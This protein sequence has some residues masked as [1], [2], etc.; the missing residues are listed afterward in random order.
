MDVAV[1]RVLKPHGIRG[2]LVVEVRTDEPR[3]RFAVGA[4]LGVSQRLPAPPGDRR[5]VTVSSAREHSGRLIVCFEGVADRA[6]AEALRGAVLTVDQAQLPPTDDPE[7]FYDHELVGLTVEL[8]DGGTIG[9][10]ADV[11]HG[12]GGDMLVV[13]REGAPDALVPFVHQL[14]PTVDVAAGRI[15]VDPPEGLLD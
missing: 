13:A 8:V 11:M 10:V 2:E 6:A 5:A 15:L 3:Q 14:V 9:S 7:E 12:P 1:G 4:V